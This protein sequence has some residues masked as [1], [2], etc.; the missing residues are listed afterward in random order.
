MAE[1]PVWL[2]TALSG[3]EGT[4]AAVAASEWGVADVIL[5]VRAADAILSTR[6]F[7]ILIREAAPLPAFDERA[8]GE[9]LVAAAIPPEQQVAE[10]AL[11]RVELVAVLRSLT[12][13]QQQ[14]AGQHE[15]TGPVK[16]VDVC[17]SIADHEL[18]HCAQLD[19]IVRGQ[20]AR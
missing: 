13:G 11:R 5:H 18:E 14:M 20:A 17:R 12:L 10:F 3:S 15:L 1:T 2:R 9:L 19:R 6:I 8:W 16:V 7:Q 4:A